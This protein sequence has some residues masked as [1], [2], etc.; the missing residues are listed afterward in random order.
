MK[1]L[2]LGLMVASVALAGS[3]F[4]NVR[5]ADQVYITGQT[6]TPGIDLQYQYQAEPKSCDNVESKPCQLEAVGYTFGS[7]GSIS[8]S[9]L[10]NPS[11]VTIQ[12]RQFDY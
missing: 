3:A 1:R 11:Q 9:D 7:S 5:N 12:S 8:E 2:F 10:N 6:G 4:T